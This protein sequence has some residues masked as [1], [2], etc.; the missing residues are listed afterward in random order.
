MAQHLADFR[1]RHP[2]AQHVDGKSMTK[3]MRPGE[4]EFH[5]GAFDRAPDDLADV[6]VRTQ[7]IKGRPRAQ[8]DAP[9]GRFRSPVLQVGCNRVADIMWQGQR[10]L[11]SAFAM[12]P[13]APLRP[14]DIIQVEADD[15]PCAQPEPRK[16]QQDGSIAQPRRCAP[17]FAF[18]QKSTNAIS[19]HRSWNRC[20]RP[21]SDAWDGRGK[22]DLDVV[23]VPRES[24]E[25]PQRRHYV[26]RCGECPPSRRVAPD[27]IGDV[28]GPYGSK[29]QVARTTYACQEPP[30]CSGV[31]VDRRGCE[32]TFLL[33]V[34]SVL[35][36]ISGQ[37]RMSRLV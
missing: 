35:L 27:I 13:Q 15:F 21:S 34:G 29:P 33:Q 12:H 28:P 10:P 23:A 32:T 3:L 7:A 22:V 2:L 11:L 36:Q 6:A 4:V 16:Q 5:S 25:R 30:D 31:V 1:Q 14:V 19:R 26:L 8:E 18:I 9:A 37:S 24:E 17:R 20:H